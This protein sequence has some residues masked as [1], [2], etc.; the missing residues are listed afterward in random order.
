MNCLHRFFM[1]HVDFLSAS[2][3]LQQTA[4][5]RQQELN[6]VK[7]LCIVAVTALTLAMAAPVRAWH[8][9]GHNAVARVA[10]SKLVEAGLDRPAIEILNA[11]PHRDIFLLAGRP[12]DVEPNEWM[13]VQAATW[14]D[15]VRR[16]FARGLDDQAAKTLAEEFNR[17]V[18]HYINL[19]YIHPDEKG[20]FDEAALKN[21]ILKPEL[22]AN[23]APR[24][25]VAAIKHNLILLGEPSTSPA[26]R[27][28]ALC[29]VLHLIGDLHQPLHAVGL[30]G[31]KE[32]IGKEDLL[33]PSGDQGGN[34]LAVRTSADLPGA[35][36]LHFYWDALVFADEPYLAVQARILAMLNG[37]E[38][39]RNKFG[40]ALKKADALEWAEE[41]QA[42]AKEVVYMDEGK[43]LQ[44]EALPDRYPKTM[45][46][47]LK[48]PV[49]SEQYQKRA[50]KVAQQRIVLAGYR[51]GDALVGA[52]QKPTK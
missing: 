31:K 30:I 26:D 41:S 44:V 42:V 45:L 47:N 36:S 38:F 29:W 15:W 14:P 17:P 46:D 22:D 3:D 21:S 6:I 24:H 10:W 32:A 48:A 1:I 7:H 13:F 52:L 40:D 8:N 4:V 34:R 12:E 49:L 39:Q 33:P 50:D 35:T 2:L 23:G 37:A 20:H 51:L 9:R 16:P 25:V 19:P 11:H 18:W 27:A 28:V 5:S 43:F